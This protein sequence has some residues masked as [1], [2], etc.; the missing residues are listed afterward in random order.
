MREPA[1]EYIAARRVLLDALAAL[2][3]HLDNLILVGAQAVYHHTGDSN[4]NVPL[5]TTDADLAINAVDLAE[6][7]EIGGVL[8]A[9]GF[10]PGPNPG[11]WVAMSDVAVDMMVVPHQAG[12]SKAAAR[13]A[14]L[15]PHERFTAR[16]ARGLEPA[17]IDNQTVLITALETSDFRRF[18]LRVAG[19][20]A[21]LTAKSIKIGE[22]LV[23]SDR[24]PDRLKEKDALDS[25]RLLQ[26]VE[27]ANLVIG[28]QRHA[29]D[30]HAAVVS[31]EAIDLLRADASTA[32]S[33]IPTLAASAAGGDPSVAPAFAALV[34]ELLD[35]LDGAL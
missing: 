9:A 21:L 1:P 2:E 25:F 33:R 19:P 30:D 12:T 24:Q 3:D 8:R 31:A 6:A 22:R 26:A 10:V 32:Q 18:E 14:Q 23:Q 17:L 34:S 16:I 28:F 5:M 11:H 29:A 20:A 4:L 35:A 7:P 15:T 27:T 13:A